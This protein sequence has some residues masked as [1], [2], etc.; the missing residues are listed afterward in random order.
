MIL[1]DGVP[2]AI[3]FGDLGWLP[4]QI[5]TD[6]DEPSPLA[7]DFTLPTEAGTEYIWCLRPPLL[8]SGTEGCTDEGA[9]WLIGAEPG[10]YARDYGLFKMPASGAPEVA[11][12]TITTTVGTVTPPPPDVTTQPTAQAVSATETATF[13]YAFSDTTSVQ[14][15]RRANAGAPWV[16]VSGAGLTSYTTPATSSGDNG[17]EYRF[18]AV[19]PGGG[20]IYTNTV[21][22]TVA[23]AQPALVNPVLFEDMLSHVLPHV[24]SCPTPTVE[25][26]LRKVATDFFQRTLAWREFLTP[27]ATVANQS[28]YTMTLPQQTTVAKLLSYSM[29]GDRRDVIDAE[30]GE[31]LALEESSMQV[32]WTVDRAVASISPTPIEN[33][34]QLV[35]RVAL[36]PSRA[37]TAIPGLMYEHYIDHI[38]EGVLANLKA[39]T[40]KDWTDTAAA[41][42]H[43][44]AYELAVA[45]V[46]MMTSKGFSRPRRKRQWF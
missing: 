18:G 36:K 31:E 5:P 27:V 28:V 39:M 46:S 8:S 15:Q 43:R 6:G 19:G 33:G 7:N 32:S 22:L 34:K 42:A 2:T 4:S 40:R 17:A 3:V 29:D 45:R 24:P 14:A 16:N 26:H 21:G 12:F 13:T 30:A 25:H 1:F 38:T 37:A 9:Y 10:V 44:S 35:F 23:T 41:T 11:D 20:P